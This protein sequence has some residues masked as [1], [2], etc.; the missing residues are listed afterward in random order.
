[1]VWLLGSLGVSSRCGV[2]CC[3]EDSNNIV[4]FNSGGTPRG[5][6]RY[7]MAHWLSAVYVLGVQKHFCVHRL[8]VGPNVLV[9]SM[10]VDRP[11]ATADAAGSLLF[12]VRLHRV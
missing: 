7:H 11:L 3:S 4:S 8:A 1:V 6:A 5:A 9:T 12:G 2:L 10:W